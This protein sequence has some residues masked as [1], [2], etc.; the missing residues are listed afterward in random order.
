MLNESKEQVMHYEVAKIT[1]IYLLQETLKRVYGKSPWSYTV[2]WSELMKKNS[3]RYLKAFKNKIY[4]GFIGMR[5][6]EDEA[7][8][9][10][11]AVLPSFQNQGLGMLLLEEGEKYAKDRGFTKI[12]LEVKKSNKQGIRLYTKYGFSVV[13]TKVGYYKETGE[14][15]IEMLYEIGD[16]YER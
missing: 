14:D 13:G 5:L 6:L 1:D 9:T 2:F 16:G 11:I 15:A 3:S 10:N 7:H 12:S 8:V 4:I